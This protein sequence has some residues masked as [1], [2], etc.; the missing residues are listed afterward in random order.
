MNKKLSFEQMKSF[1]YGF[2]KLVL[3]DSN[4]KIVLYVN[5]VKDKNKF[6]LYFKAR[7]NLFYVNFIKLFSNSPPIS[8]SQ[9]NKL[10]QEKYPKIMLRGKQ[11]I[12]IDELVNDFNLNETKVITVIF[13]T[14]RNKFLYRL[15][16]DWHTP[17]CAYVVAHTEDGYSSTK[18]S[19]EYFSFDELLLQTDLAI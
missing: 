14:I 10:F 6:F 7:Q 12:S 19:N 5:S 15:K 3:Q 11:Y 16:H 8:I 9:L 18:V 4:A 2:P 17:Q 13:K 1:V